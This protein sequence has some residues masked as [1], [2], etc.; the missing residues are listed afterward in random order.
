M[1]MGGDPAFKKQSKSHPFYLL[2]TYVF[3]KAQ[4]NYLSGPAKILNFF[5]IELK[6]NTTCIAYQHIKT[7]FCSPLGITPG[8]KNMFFGFLGIHD[9][10]DIRSF[11]DCG[12]KNE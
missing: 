1:Y 10:P 4:T 2:R 7:R 6:I 12:F 8:A 11:S 5:T 3:G 9:H